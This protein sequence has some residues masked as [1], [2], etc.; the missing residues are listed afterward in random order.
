MELL[1]ARLPFSHP[2]PFA[3]KPTELEDPLI[4][5]DLKAIAEQFHSGKTLEKIDFGS[6]NLKHMDKLYQVYLALRKYPSPNSL[7]DGS[8]EVV[9]PSREVEPGPPQN[10]HRLGVAKIAPTPN[11]MPIMK[12]RTRLKLTAADLLQKGEFQEWLLDAEIAIREAHEDFRAGS[13]EW[14]EIERLDREYR[15]L[16]DEANTFIAVVHADQREYFAARSERWQ[17]SEKGHAYQQWMDEWDIEISSDEL[18]DPK[19]GGDLELCALEM[20]QDLPDQPMV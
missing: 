10:I 2:I 1:D 6:A 4:H 13:G 9:L 20:L 14:S 16:V 12:S 17:R 3:F 5:K 15:Q 19:L 11:P 7:S 8:N 18:P